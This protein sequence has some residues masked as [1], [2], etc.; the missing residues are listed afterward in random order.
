MPGVTLRNHILSDVEFAD[1]RKFR[2]LYV[3]GDLW[4]CTQRSN[5]RLFS[6]LGGWCVGFYIRH[7]VGFACPLRY[8]LLYFTRSRFFIL[9]YAGVERR[10]QPIEAPFCCLHSAPLSTDLRQQG[11]LTSLFPA[12]RI[13]PL[14]KNQDAPYFAGVTLRATAMG[15]PPPLDSDALQ[16]NPTAKMHPADPPHLRRQNA[17]ARSGFTFSFHRDI[18]AIAFPREM[19]K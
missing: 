19:A 2:I 3:F 17:D 5:Y 18:S 4:P 11:N 16:R 1:G 13:A 9:F 10:N 15:R 12:C 14:F 7:L 8:S 6:R